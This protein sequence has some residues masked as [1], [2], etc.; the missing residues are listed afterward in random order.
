M[1]KKFSFKNWQGLTIRGYIHK[2]KKY[3][4][5]ILTLHGFPG[6]CT[7]KRVINTAKMLERRGFLV[8]R[9]DF[10][11]SR[12]SEGKFEDKLMS[13]EVK[14]IKSAI[15]F[16]HDN[17]HFKKL[18]VHGHST[19]A[20]V[21]SL[22]AHKD[23]RISK[24]VL[25]GAV[26]NLKTAVRFDFTDEQVRTFWLKGYIV[27]KKSKHWTSGKKLKKA[28]YDEFFKLD[29]HK[30]MKSYRRPLLILHGEKDKA[31]PVECAYALYGIAHKPKKIIIIKGADHQFS[32]RK[33]L[34]Q[35]VESMTK[36]AS[37]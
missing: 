16:L 13:S 10:A 22:Y 29:I 19:G 12:I 27:Y 11:G 28:F 37:S 18:I 35:C 21:A 34:K 31:V 33:W 23:K 4:A 36:F 32:Q 8:M 30:A 26:E 3:Q 7:S 14:D 20:I 9:F 25:S 17:Y 6:S 5:A 2:P 24:L 15:D 1:L